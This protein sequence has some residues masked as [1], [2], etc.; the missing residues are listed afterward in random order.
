MY[1]KPVP[2]I[3]RGFFLSFSFSLPLLLPFLCLSFVF[4]H[5]HAAPCFSGSNIILFQK[6]RRLYYGKRVT[7]LDSISKLHLAKLKRVE[8]KSPWIGGKNITV[9]SAHFCLLQCQSAE[10]E[11][12]PFC[13][14]FQF[15][16]QE[17]CWRST[18]RS[19]RHLTGVFVTYYLNRPGLNSGNKGPTPRKRCSNLQACRNLL[20]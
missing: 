4:L 8:T 6:L 14:P 11:G 2:S 15:V 17:I 16:K 1:S 5:N 18:A 20:K 7:N 19:N 3:S 13:S 12:S 9:I 10:G